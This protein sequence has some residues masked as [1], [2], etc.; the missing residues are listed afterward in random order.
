MTL[1]AEWRTNGEFDSVLIIENDSTVREALRA[2]ADVLHRLLTDFGD[3]N[4]WRGDVRVEGDKGMPS[5][6]GKLVIARAQT[7]EVLTMDPEAF[8]KGIHVWFRSRGVDYDTPIAE[9]RV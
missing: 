7:G 3:L 8:W 4:S 1:T 2:N 5:A 9:E 6:W